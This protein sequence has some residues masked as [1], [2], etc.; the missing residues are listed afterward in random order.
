MCMMIAIYEKSEMELQK[1]WQKGIAPIKQ[2]EKQCVLWLKHHRYEFFYNLLSGFQ[3][4]CCEIKNDL[5]MLEE[6]W[7]QVFQ[8]EMIAQSSYR[9]EFHKIA[10]W[11]LCTV[12]T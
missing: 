11:L 9:S 2:C 12:L 1:K 10:A 6:E 7:S 4:Q 5:L 3:A 8:T